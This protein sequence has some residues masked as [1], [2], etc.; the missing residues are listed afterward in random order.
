MLILGLVISLVLFPVMIFQV[1]RSWQLASVKLK[2][3]A[4]ID[5]LQ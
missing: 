3:G 1:I 4:L 5:E 2:Q